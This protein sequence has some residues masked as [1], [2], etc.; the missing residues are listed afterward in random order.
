MSQAS[1]LHIPF[2]TLPPEC[3]ALRAEV[4][5]FLAETLP[6]HR[7]AVPQTFSAF[8]AEFSRKLGAR[9]WIGMT[10]PKQ[11]GGHERSYLER[12]V[13]V[14][15][16]LAANAPVLA[17][18]IADRQS[19]PQLLRFGSEDMR[20]RMLP[21]I[22]RGELYFC[23]GMS[24]P[25]A[26]SD[27]ASIRTRGQRVQGVEGGW[28][29]NGRKIWNTAHHAHY[30]IALVRTTKSDANRHFG[31]SQF[32]IDLK[33]PGISIRRLKNLTGVEGFSEVLFEDVLVPQASLLGIEG[34]GWKQVTTELGDERAGPE[35]YLSSF[36]LLTHMLDEAS[37]SDDRAVVAL[38][39]CVAEARTL[40]NMSLGLAGMS[41][42]GEDISSTAAMFKEL[43]TTFEQSVPDLA[44]SL[45]DLEQADPN[46]AL[47]VTARRIVQ[48][49]PSYSL[50]GGSREVLKGVIARKLGLR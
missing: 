50:R 41:S 33:T 30:M 42:R 22:A 44:A 45:F 2:C 12:Y 7:N 21:A 31:L 27:L 40:R 23:L 49:S 5:R 37:A 28:L 38:G 16:L 8:D 17:H 34:E 15:E 48:V 19:G 14:E 3:A 10:W 35:R 39:Q 29:I 26:G 25:D 9:G 6:S 24:E 46:S 11:Y 43:G 47:A 13:V 32:V 1:P 20:E 36:Q 18:W 4:R